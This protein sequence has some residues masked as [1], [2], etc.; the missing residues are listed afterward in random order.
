MHPEIILGP[1]G[2]GKTTCLLGMVDDEL[3]SGTDP[4]R[5]GYVSFTRKAAHEA[6]ER[7]CERFTLTHAQL[8]YFRTLHSLCFLILGLSPS[9]VLE[10][11]RLIE[12]GDWAGIRVTSRW[13]MDEGTPFGFEVGDRILFM[14]NL[15]RIRCQS[16]RQQYDDDCDDLPWTEVSRVSRALSEFKQVR[17]LLDY[18]DMLTEVVASGWKSRLEVLFVDE[19]QDLSQLQWRLVSKL[20]TTCRRVVV[21]GDDDQAIYRWAGADV[22]HFVAL[23]GDTRVLSQSWRCPMAVQELS[24]GLVSKIHHRREKV[25]LP[26]TAAGVLKYAGNIDDVNLEGKDV[27]ILARNNYMLRDVVVP[28]LRS[29]GVL[30]EWRGQSSV[31]EPVLDAIVTWERLRR[32]DDVTVDEVR[33]A[34]EYMSI[35]VGVA[36]GF[37]TLPGR[38]ADERTGMRALQEHGGLL[39]DAIWHDA[40]DRIPNGEKVYLLRALRAGERLARRPRI[41]LSTIHG[42]KGGEADHV[43]LMT[44]MALRT[45]REMH[46]HPDDEHRVWYVAVTRAREALT[47]MM[48]STNRYFLL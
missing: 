2:T 30:F 4:G 44:D 15:S 32:G 33:R 27:M 46:A 16:L 20:A 35:G 8:P 39:T 25:W 13:S 5:I 1:P 34:Y 40:L 48:P 28:M 41:R 38:D 17:R 23:P 18:T 24:Q 29:S 45:H 42:A 31:S 10:R 37:K 6:T 43:I 3:R 12:F 9:D 14:E 21:A 47:V 22:D 11:G 7:A 36:R 19:A 26:R